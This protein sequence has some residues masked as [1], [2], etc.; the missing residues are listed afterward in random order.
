M[1]KVFI[2]TGKT[3]HLMRVM[4]RHTTD[5]NI[6]IAQFTQSFFLRLRDHQRHLCRLHLISE[7]SRILLV[8]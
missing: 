6:V 8:I 7:R 2:P 3:E 5:F 1:R 4:W